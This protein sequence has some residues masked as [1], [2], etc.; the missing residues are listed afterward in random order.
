MRKLDMRRTST[1]DGNGNVVNIG[2]YC[3]IEG[4]QQGQR[5]GSAAKTGPEGGACIS[6]RG[7]AWKRHCIGRY[8]C[9]C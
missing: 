9:I 6:M 1:V 3:T 7:C 5:P 2:D 8:A 4:A